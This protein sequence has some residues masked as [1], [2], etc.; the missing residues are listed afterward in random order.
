MAAACGEI[1]LESFQNMP[2]KFG[3]DEKPLVRADKVREWRS[4]RRETSFVVGERLRRDEIASP[5]VISNAR[6]YAGVYMNSPCEGYKGREREGGRQRGRG[7]Q[8]VR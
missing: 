1:R 3:E 2:L 5:A 7:R 6:V 8:R 4:V